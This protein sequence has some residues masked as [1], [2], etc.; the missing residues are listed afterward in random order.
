MTTSGHGQNS[1][2]I[3]FLSQGD[4]I[5]SIR[6]PNQ[7]WQVVTISNICKK[8]VVTISDTYCNLNFEKQQGSCR[9][10]AQ[11]LTHHQ[12]LR[13]LASLCSDRYGGGRQEKEDEGL[14][15]FTE[16]VVKDDCAAV[17][18]AAAEESN[19]SGKVEGLLKDHHSSPKQE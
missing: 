15:S 14:G 2:N 4:M 19:N 17:A 12:T 1:H 8:V 7:G 3:Q 18:A 13:Q 10:L 5:Y 11:F 9:D 6:K 16:A